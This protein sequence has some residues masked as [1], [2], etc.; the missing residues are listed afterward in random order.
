MKQSLGYRQFKFS[1]RI[2]NKKIRQLNIEKYKKINLKRR[3][4]YLENENSVELF[5]YA[6][7]GR[8]YAI[9]LSSGAIISGGLAAKYEYL[10]E[11]GVQK[12]YKITFGNSKHIDIIEDEIESIELIKPH[13]TVLEYLKEFENK[14]DVKCF[15]KEDN[16]LPNDK[17]LSNLLFGKEQTWDDLHEDEKRDFISYLQLSSDEVVTLINILVDYKDENKKLYDK[18]QSTLD[19]T[20]DFVNQFDEIKEVF[21][22]LEELIAFVYKKLGIETLVNSITR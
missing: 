17:I 18:R 13:K 16:V 9:Q 14:H 7:I 5:E 2:P 3:I 21:P 22:S 20:L 8:T 11:E 6:E 1:Q 4:L 10:T 12:V 19:A 15:D